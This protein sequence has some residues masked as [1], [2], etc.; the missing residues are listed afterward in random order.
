[1][2][3]ELKRSSGRG[4]DEWTLRSLTR[5]AAQR[6]STQ[7]CG[8]AVQRACVAVSA[9]STDRPQRRRGRT[10]GFPTMSCSGRIQG[11]RAQGCRAQARGSTAHRTPSW[12]LPPSPPSTS[13]ADSRPARLPDF[14]RRCNT[15][16]VQRVRRLRN[17]HIRHIDDLRLRKNLMH[18]TVTAQC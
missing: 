6:W 18:C 14:V 3:E 1:M 15:R 9:R 17:A 5:V 12:I 8:H 10:V 13:L 7:P 16:R 2:P 11:C 4:H